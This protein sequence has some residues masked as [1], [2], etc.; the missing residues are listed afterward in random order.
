MGYKPRAFLVPEFVRGV[1]VS[2]LLSMAF[3]PTRH[4]RACLFVVH[5]RSNLATKRMQSVWI[6]VP[7]FLST[8]LKY[9]PA[10]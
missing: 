7:I 4:E 9:L 1:D 6:L 2:P 10:A 5:L 8:V 3:V